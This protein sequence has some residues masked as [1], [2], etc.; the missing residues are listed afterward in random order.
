[1]NHKNEKPPRRFDLNRYTQLIKD[2]LPVAGRHNAIIENIDHSEKTEVTWLF[3]DWKI[4][5]CEAPVRQFLAVDALDVDGEEPSFARRKQV[6]QG[7]YQLLLI[8]EAAGVDP[9]SE[10]SDI[11]D[12]Q[13]LI[14]TKAEIVV[15]RRTSYGVP[16]ATVK[17]VLK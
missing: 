16:E 15:G 11:I 8:C 10:I 4:D 2:E 12:F 6:G 14:G 7:L 17:T 9:V 3:V 5:G 1:M 13:T